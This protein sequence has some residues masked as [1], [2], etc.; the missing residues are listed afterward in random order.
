M[1]GSLEWYHPRLSCNRVFLF[2]LFC[3]FCFNFHT[4]FPW[5]HKL[6]QLIC[7]WGQRLEAFGRPSS[8]TPLPKCSL[9][10]LGSG[11]GRLG[12]CY[13]KHF[14]CS[15]RS[16][17]F[18]PLKAILSSLCH[19]CKLELCEFFQRSSAF[20]WTKADLPSKTQ[21]CINAWLCWQI[22]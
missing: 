16:L 8:Y 21:N 20:C 18:L 1:T 19:C 5:H 9:F 6:H 11:S 15:A 3:L 17:A 12:K 22:H 14:N 7:A 10:L 4:H 2:W 13:E